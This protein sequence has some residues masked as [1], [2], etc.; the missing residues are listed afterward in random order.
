MKKIYIA[1]LTL[2]A[3][4]SLGSCGENNAP[5]EGNGNKTEETGKPVEPEK[6]AL[7]DV[8][9][10]LKLS[11]LDKPLSDS[12]KL[13]KAINYK[14]TS[15]SLS[16]LSDS[17]YLELKEEAND[18]LATV[19]R[20]ENVNAYGKLIAKVSDGNDFF[21]KAFD[22][23]VLQKE[24]NQINLKE[25]ISGLNLE[26]LTK[27]LVGNFSLPK[28]YTFA[29]ETYNLTYTTD[30]IDYLEFVPNDKEIA[31]N[32]SKAYVMEQFGY[33]RVNLEINGK[34]YY[35]EYQVTIPKEATE[36]PDLQMIDILYA[37]NIP[38]FKKPIASDFDLPAAIDYKGIHYDIYWTSYT[39][40]LN[41]DEN[42]H[43]T[44]A[45]PTTNSE[46]GEINVMIMDDVEY[47]TID[48]TI[49]VTILKDGLD[50][51][52]KPNLNEIA[53]TI[54]L[55][56]GIKTLNKDFEVEKKLT[57]NGL[58][59]D[60]E[61]SLCENDLLTIEDNGTYKTIKVKQPELYDKKVLIKV[62]IV[63]GFES[64]TKTFELT[65]L[66]KSNPDDNI[67][68]NGIY[69]TSEDVSTYIIKFN[70]L[71][72]NYYSKDEFDQIVDSWT[73]IN[74]ISCGGRAWENRENS[75]PQ[76]DYYECDILG[77]AEQRGV[78]RLVYSL[79]TKNIYYTTDH[80]KTFVQLYKDGKK[81]EAK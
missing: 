6:V 78:K 59:Y 12:F 66:S 2:L 10:T 20:P 49:E 61:Y 28:T 77:Q 57:I 81:V 24:V 73:I 1:L 21:E 53:N 44:V 71:P 62:T 29:S 23:S 17:K 43:V 54:A 8:I 19:T 46:I 47:T 42:N 7:S 16:Y 60:I 48:T 5:Q 58:N 40:Y 36:G 18:F 15:Y 34:S 22:F 31:V 50:P 38:E 79:K 25:L 68:E 30:L 72:K 75:L 39:E 11:E 56:N 27:P 69:W 52:F 67:K 80:Y 45:R 3:V 64:A 55:N 76:D 32:L 41:I 33:V 37:I 35:K 4:F 14:N 74:K 65:I 13:P 51:A 70:K 63:N 26:V 9:N